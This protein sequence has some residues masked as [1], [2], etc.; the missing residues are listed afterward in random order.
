MV[1]ATVLFIVILVKAD[2]TAVSDQPFADVT[3]NLPAMHTSSSTLILNIPAFANGEAIPAQY[4]CDGDA[5][6]SPE[7]RIAGV[8]EGAQS[9]AL[10]M[11]DPDVP[12]EIKQDG[13]FDHWVLYDIP[14]QTELIPQGESAGKAGQNGSGS[15]AYTGPC[16]PPQYEP[17][18]HRYVFTLY[19]LDVA[20][21]AL[22]EAPTKAQVIEAMRG[23]VIAE[24]SY[25]GRYKRQ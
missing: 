21:L 3:F 24:A 19:A 11:D 23:H 14:P 22:G 15:P 5:S 7:I 13:M 20:A 1:V 4:T 18:E 2:H 8:P 12:K 25:T 16:P 9:L 17:S 6:L 10:I